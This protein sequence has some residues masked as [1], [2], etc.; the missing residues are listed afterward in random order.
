MPKSGFKTIA[1]QTNKWQQNKRYS[2]TTI[3]AKNRQ[4]PK[5]NFV[6]H[7]NPQQYVKRQH[8]RHLFENSDLKQNMISFQ[9]VISNDTKKQPNKQLKL[10]IL[11]NKS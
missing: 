1:Q 6:I 11:L 9:Y 8:I 4:T 5:P 2:I 3:Q 7:N 10:K